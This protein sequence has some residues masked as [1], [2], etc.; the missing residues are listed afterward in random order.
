MSLRSQVLF[1]F[2]ALA[3]AHAQAAGSLAV[4]V[5]ATVVP[6]C[7]FFTSAP[8]L[9]LRNTGTSGRNIDPSSATTAS[10]N[11][12]IRYRC[13][14]RTL[15]LFTIPATATMTC[16]ACPGAPTLVA[17][18]TATDSGVGTGMGSTHNRTLT[19][20]GQIT[21]ATFQN[22]R[23]GAYTGNMTVTVTP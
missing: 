9:N 21:Q 15:P 16:A 11:R 4:T 8:V 12:A 10:G 19:I 13:T 23:V 14:N 17:T 2:A 20:A 7:K 1:A 5:N 22:A 18:I 6:V 3:C